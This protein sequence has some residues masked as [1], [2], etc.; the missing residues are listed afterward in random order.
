[1]DLGTDKNGFGYGFTGK[2]SNNRNFETY[3]ET[4]TKGDVI[5]CYIDCDSG[6]IGFSK[7]GDEYLIVNE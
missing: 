1:L 5:G 2:K 6:E 4:Y 7:N 3:G